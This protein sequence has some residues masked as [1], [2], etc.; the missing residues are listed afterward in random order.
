MRSTHESALAALVHLVERARPR[1]GGYL[2]HLG[3][4]FIAVGV[5]SSQFYQ[6]ARE[7]TRSALEN[8]GEGPVEGGTTEPEDGAPEDGER[9][10]A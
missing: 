1:Y 9:P 7:V 3:M 5:I 2:V 10:S 8:A 4:A 6:Y